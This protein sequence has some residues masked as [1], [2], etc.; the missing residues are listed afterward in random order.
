MGTIAARDA[1]RVCTLTERV[2][3]IHLLAAAQACD[4]RANIRV[5]PLLAKI[6]GNIRTVSDGVVEDRPL[7][8]DI[9]RMCV[10]IRYTDFFR[11]KP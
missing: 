6:L 2:L 11:M 10:V 3:A 9:E 8:E 7:D 4:I 1:E 5:R